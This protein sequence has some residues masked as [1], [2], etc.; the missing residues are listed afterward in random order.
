MA[1]LAGLLSFTSK[2]ILKVKLTLDMKPF[3]KLFTSTLPISL[4]S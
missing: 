3:Y 2:W 4:F 1:Y